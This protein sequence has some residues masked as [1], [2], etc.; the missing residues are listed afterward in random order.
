MTRVRFA[1]LFLGLSATVATAQPPGA[2]VTTPLV[3]R[4]L[5]FVDDEN[6]GK[7]LKL[8]PDQVKKLVAYRQ[9]QWDEQYTTAQADYAKGAADR[10]KSTV[11]LF[12]DVLSADQHKRAVQ[13]AANVVWRSGAFGGGG[14]SVI[15][16]TPDLSKIPTNTL[17][18]YAEIAEALNLT[19]EQNQLVATRA[20]NFGPQVFLTPEQSRAARQL[21]GET[22]KSNWKSAFDTR[23]TGGFGGG[24]IVNVQG[25]LGLTE[26]K[27]VRT[28][29]ALTDEQVQVLAPL[30]EK[31]RAITGAQQDLSPEA[32]AKQIAEWTAATDKTLAATLKPEQ[33]T[34]LR[35]IEQQV[36]AGGLSFALGGATKAVPL[37]VQLRAQVI[38]KALTVTAEQDK[39]LAAADKIN[40]AAIYAAASANGPVEDA[41][42]AIAAA[43][44]SREKAYAAVLTVE[45]TKKLAD[46]LGKPFIGNVRP[47]FGNKGLSAEQLKMF[48]SANFGQRAIVEITLLARNKSIQDDLKLSPEQVKQAVAALED[49]QNKFPPGGG[50]G[51]LEEATKVVAEQAAY[52][53]KVVDGILTA[54]QAKRH[55]ELMLQRAENLL[56]QAKGGFFNTGVG[57]VG[58]P[59]IAEAV[60][61]SSAQK[62]KL[63]D[64]DTPSAVLTAD[65]KAA[66]KNMLGKEFQGNFGF[67]Q[68]PGPGAT[69]PTTAAVLVNVSWDVFKLTPEQVTKLVPVANEYQRETANLGGKGGKGGKQVN[70]APLAAANDKLAKALA[71]ILTPAQAKRVEQVRYQLF[72]AGSSLPNHLTNA[73]VAKALD[74]KEAQRTSITAILNGHSR[75]QNAARGGQP[76]GGGG[77]GT[78]AWLPKLNEVTTA[79]ALAVLTDEQ[80]A[81]WTRLTGDPVPN[82][83]FNRGNFGGGGGFPGGF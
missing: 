47:G 8:T 38:R 76:F 73:E 36:K 46:L 7:E 5:P 17:A 54:D 30:L 68:R 55:R 45:Q 67:A 78:L 58:Y 56:N 62:T 28:E 72:A 52:A 24:F 53:A 16:Q 1:L 59:G 57:A 83:R 64:G 74:L 29:I 21:L 66:I 32:Q 10:T 65:Q 69:S 2:P 44:D 51:T 81:T 80:R 71:Q 37:S 15:I 75:L 79:R 42:Q 41:I 70:P 27:D 39:T 63:L 19:D 23:S 20:Q 26:A 13:L 35:Q 14:G 22:V 77:P 25:P 4:L 50:G 40:G 60:K 31:W 33:L 43:N 18:Q 48:R 3:T 61:L 49:A 6:F 12:K 34:R 9:K 11:S 82:L